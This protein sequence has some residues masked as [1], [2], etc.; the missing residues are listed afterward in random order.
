VVLGG[1]LPKMESDSDGI[2]DVVVDDR[3]HCNPDTD[4]GS[5][6]YRTIS[7]HNFGGISLSGHGCIA[8]SHGD[9]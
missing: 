1:G 9:G 3:A 4:S 6:I 7:Y 5:M 2:Q 8:E